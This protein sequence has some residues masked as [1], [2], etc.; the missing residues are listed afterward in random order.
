MRPSPV[1]EGNQLAGKQACGGE[2]DETDAERLDCPF[3][4]RPDDVVDDFVCVC[5]EGEGKLDGVVSLV[6]LGMRRVTNSN[7]IQVQPH[8]RIQYQND[9]T[10]YQGRGPNQQSSEEEE[11][12]ALKRS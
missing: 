11:A 3:S 5:K 1:I 7:P 9:D 8:G 2:I 6:F 4:K 12:M 10:Q